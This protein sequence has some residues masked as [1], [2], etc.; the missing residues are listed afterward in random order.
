MN[1]LQEALE[2]C[3]K[4]IE[5]GADINSVLFLYPEFADELRPLLEASVNAR[6]IAVPPPSAEV[7][8]R[9]RAKVL[10]RAAEMR[11]TRIKPPARRIWLVSLR[12]VAVAFIVVAILFAS[13]TNLVRAA[14]TTLPGDQLYPVKRTWEDVLV[15]LAFNVQQRDAL[16]VE[17]ENERL[18]ELQELFAVGR[19]AKVD[20]AG[21]VTSQKGNDWVVAGI[22]VLISSQ[23]ELR[24]QGIA[25]GSAVRVE[26]QTQ[27]NGVVL[28]NRI[29]LLPPGAIVPDEQETEPA[30]LEVESTPGSS[31][32]IEEDSGR[33]SLAEDNR[34][35]NQETQ[36]PE[37]TSEPKDRTEN[38]STEEPSYHNQQDSGGEPSSHNGSEDS[39]GGGDH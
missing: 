9:N 6:N 15:L 38:Q 37:A 25:V 35:R 11:T 3:L 12:R 23:T 2:I 4:E 13:G 14:S 34:P 7:E 5:Q 28:A 17:H 29:Q 20:F 39:G 8:W 1:E 36:V 26:G 30:G 22:P 24:N 16:E 32:Q 19:T 21:S 10:Q 18:H 33:Q 31:L 27:S